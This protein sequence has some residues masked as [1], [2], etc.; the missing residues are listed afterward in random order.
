[1]AIGLTLAAMLIVAMPAAAVP[2][3]WTSPTRVYTDS[4]APTHAMVTDPAGYTHI[5]TQRGSSGIWYVTN[6]S[7]SWASCQL[8]SGNDREPSIAY[9]GGVVHV[10]FARRTSGQEGIYSTSSDRPGSAAGCGWAITRRYAGKS[11]DPSLAAYEGTLSIAFRSTYRKLK[12]AKGPASSDTW[13]VLEVIDTNCCTSAPSLDLTTTGAP[14]VAYGDGTRKALGL[15]YAVRAGAG[16]KKSKVSGGRV[17]HV[18]MVLDKSPGVFAPP[19]NAPKIV[20]VLKKRGT[21]LATKGS[22][23]AGGAWGNRFFGK[24]F[25]SPDVSHSSNVTNL[26]YGGSGRLIWVRMSGA[27]WQPQTFS[28]TGRDVKPQLHGSVVTFARKSGAP[29]IYY[30]HH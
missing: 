5:A 7:G 23:Y 15:R 13:N 25:G 12:F 29:G 9:G 26:I 20:Y 19:S 2:S 16:W 27:I 11:S 24:Y 3:G 28:S 21:Y 17:L 14:R 10:A 1:M 8:S 30:T 22:S 4:S 6:A 18:S